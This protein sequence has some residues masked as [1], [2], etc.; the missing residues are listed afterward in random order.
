MILMINYRGSA[1]R[2]IQRD[3]SNVR[4]MR[5]R[6]LKRTERNCAL[7]CAVRIR[8]EVGPK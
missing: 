7:P 5:R 4:E 8:G 3:R 6:E 2:A 1:K